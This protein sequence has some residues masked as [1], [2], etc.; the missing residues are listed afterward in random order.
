MQN[1]IEAKYT[2]V[3][4]DKPTMPST[5]F[6]TRFVYE[7]HLQLITICMSSYNVSRN[8]YLCKT[9]LE[10]QS[11]LSLLLSLAQRAKQI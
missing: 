3:L 5:L 8:L 11:D 9:C 4:C 10:N 6:C 1:M 7:I 2:H